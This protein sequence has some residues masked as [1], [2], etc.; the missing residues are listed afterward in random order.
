MSNS[1][2]EK[3]TKKDLNERK[4][5]QVRLMIFFSRYG[6][7]IGFIVLC[8]VFGLLSPFFFTTENT[9][10]VIRQVSVLG[11]ASA[12]LTAIMIAGGFD[13]SFGAAMSLIGVI[14]SIHMAHGIWVPVAFIEALAIGVGIG[15]FN[16]F[17][18]VTIG[19]P[20]FIAT[21]GTMSILTGITLTVTKGMPIYNIPSSFLFLGKGEIA[22]VIPFCV[23]VLLLVELLCHVFFQYTQ[24][25]RNLYAVGGN[26]E[27][28]RFVGIRV[29]Y[30]RY[31]SFCIGGS[32][33]GLASCV[34]TSRLG[35]AQPSA[36]DA[37]LLD[38]IASVFLGM[39]T[40]KAGEPHILGSLL[41]VL[42]IGVLRN[43]MTLLGLSFYAQEIVKGIV[44]IL[45]VASIAYIK[46]ATGETLSGGAL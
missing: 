33:F 3:A 21:L 20:D 12:G 35:S 46:K 39:T 23:V 18:I 10:N 14:V 40:L 45:A 34:L 2:V 15:L 16:A 5:K 27:A 24:M 43:G 41:G 13:L 38:V 4:A 11:I 17:L 1:T 6:V 19:I 8:S 42:I 37:Y 31:V 30:I 32:L 9:L 25:G 7:L 28:A 26:K 44:I 22:G 36:G 29:D